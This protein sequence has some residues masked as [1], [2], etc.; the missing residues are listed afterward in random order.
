MGR[1]RQATLGK[2]LRCQRHRTVATA[3]RTKRRPPARFRLGR[4]GSL[5]AMEGFGF[6]VPEVRCIMATTP[7]AIAGHQSRTSDDG[8]RP[9]LQPNRLTLNG[10]PGERSRLTAL[11]SSLH[12]RERSWLSNDRLLLCLIE[13]TLLICGIDELKARFSFRIEPFRQ[14]RFTAG[15][16]VAQHN[17]GV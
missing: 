4:L 8:S 2:V 13:L 6:S 12:G 10:F 16:C 3:E 1:D 7:R 15:P 17:C 9:M 5:G 14:N 11:F